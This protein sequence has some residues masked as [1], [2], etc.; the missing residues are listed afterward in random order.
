MNKSLITE[1]ADELFDK[2]EKDIISVNI[3]LTAKYC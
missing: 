1:T 3:L 2:A